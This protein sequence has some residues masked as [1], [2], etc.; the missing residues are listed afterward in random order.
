MRGDLELVS[1]GLAGLDRRLDGLLEQIATVTARV[2]ADRVLPVRLADR[3]KGVG[4]RRG[5]VPVVER[6]AAA[7]SI[8]PSPVRIRDDGSYRPPISTNSALP[9]TR[10]ST[11]GAAVSDDVRS[12]YPARIRRSYSLWRN[13]SN[14]S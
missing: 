11:S 2:G 6:P 3:L 10:S 9:R 5:S 4:A 12:P 8:D 1:V 14:R 7:G 13:R